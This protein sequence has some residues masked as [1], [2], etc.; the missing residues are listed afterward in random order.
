MRHTKKAEGILC[1]EK[2]RG[3]EQKK[4]EEEEEG[5]E[6]GNKGKRGGQDKLEEMVPE[7]IQTLDVLGKDLKSVAL[8]MLTLFLI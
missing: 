1:S 6:K 8:N 2:A 5:G 4:E 7:E 3:K